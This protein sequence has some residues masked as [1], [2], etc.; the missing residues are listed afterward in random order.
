VT[1]FAQY[2]G[3]YRQ[4]VLVACAGGKDEQLPA[5]PVTQGVRVTVDQSRLAQGLQGARDLGLLATDESGDLYDAHAVAAGCG[6]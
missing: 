3:R 1:E 2:A 4:Q 5:E 6:L